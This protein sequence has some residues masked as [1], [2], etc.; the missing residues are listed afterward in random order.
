MKCIYLNWTYEYIMTQSDLIQWVYLQFL[1]EE[2]EDQWY[3]ASK[4]VHKYREVG[5]YYG[6]ISKL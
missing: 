4:W 1:M 6:L 5:F 2:F 3:D